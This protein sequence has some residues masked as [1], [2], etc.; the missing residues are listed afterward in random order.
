M[1]NAEKMET[2][3][4]KFMDTPPQLKNLEYPQE[5]DGL[6]PCPAE[7]PAATPMPHGCS[8]ANGSTSLLH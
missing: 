6:S 5:C 8:Q 4:L 2:K 1:P 3:K 7:V